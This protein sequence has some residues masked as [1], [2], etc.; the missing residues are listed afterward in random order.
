VQCGF[1]VRILPKVRML[2]EQF[3]HQDGVWNLQNEQTKE[4]T[5]QVRVQQCS[6]ACVVWC[7]VCLISVLQAFLR[8]DEPSMKSFHNRIRQVRV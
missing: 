6:V 5:A 3:T 2:H 7:G 8:V 4:R 1:E